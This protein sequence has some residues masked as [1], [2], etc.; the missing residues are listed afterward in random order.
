MEH[1]RKDLPLVDLHTSPKSPLSHRYLRLHSGQT[2]CISLDEGRKQRGSALAGG[3]QAEAGQGLRKGLQ[4]GEEEEEMGQVEEVGVGELR[5][6]VK[7][8]GTR[9]GTERGAGQGK[10]LLLGQEQ[11]QPSFFP[12]Q[13]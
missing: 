8:S 11:R 4:M 5:G 2:P 6:P 3:S 7:V 9:E 1:C 13:K 12:P 10:G